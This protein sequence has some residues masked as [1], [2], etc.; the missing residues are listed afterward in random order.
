MARSEPGQC[1]PTPSPDQKVPKLTSISPTP[2]FMAF[3]G[4][5]DS[6]RPTMTPTTPTTTMAA[7]AAIVVVGVVG[8]IVGRQLSSV[9]ENAMKMG[10][11]LMLVSFGTFWSGEGV[12]VHW[13]GSELAIPVLVAVYG[14]VAWALV[15]LLDRR[16]GHTV[17]SAVGAGGAD[18]G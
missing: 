13:P 3:S 6:C 11:G 9:P 7:A 5:D 14:A 4:T 10:V 18:H 1:T 2:I 16:D 15:V 17:T 8:V 12:G